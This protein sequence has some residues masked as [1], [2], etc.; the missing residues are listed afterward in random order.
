MCDYA[1]AIGRKIKRVFSES[2]LHLDGRYN[3]EAPYEDL[4]IR[5]IDE[6]LFLLLDNDLLVRLYAT[7][8]RTADEYEREYVLG[9]DFA[10]N[11]KTQKEFEML[12]GLTISEIQEFYDELDDLDEMTDLIIVLD[13]GLRL[14][15][16]TF[17]DYFDIEIIEKSNTEPTVCYTV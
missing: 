4:S 17:L 9:T 11:E 13:S 10:A 14:I 8:F 3:E 15:C 5:R 16:T 1:F 7:S 2:E 6:P 12:C